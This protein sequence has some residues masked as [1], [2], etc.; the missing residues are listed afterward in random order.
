[1]KII[2]IGLNYKNHA[3]EMKKE[4]P[5]RPLVFIKPDS[6][7]IKN[8]KPFFIPDYNSA[9]DHEAELVLSICKVGRSIAPKFAHRYFDKITVG[10]DFTARDLQK[11]LSNEIM[12]WSI[13]KG[14]DGSAPLGKFLPISSLDNPESISFSLEKNGETVQS[15]C[16][17]DMIFSFA[18]IISYVSRF[19][20]LKTGD[21]IFTGT[22][23]GAGPVKKNDRLTAY[24]EGNKVLDFNVK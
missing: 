23:A 8:N 2:C 9:I 5:S 1:M 20:T 4:L 16:S 15:G 3:R 7:L 6:A 21:L 19:F 14:F 24:L 17:T 11:S 18:E 13:S 22:P 10:I 12:P